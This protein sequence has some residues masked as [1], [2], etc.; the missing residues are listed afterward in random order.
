M[1]SKQARWERNQRAKALEAALSEF[2]SNSDNI[3]SIQLRPSTLA[4]Y[5]LYFESEIVYVGRTTC[6]MTRL[7]AHIS[8]GI[9]FDGVKYLEVKDSKYLG[10][11]ECVYI[12]LLKPKIN[13]AGMTDEYKDRY[14]GRYKSI[15]EKYG[16]ELLMKL[17]V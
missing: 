9:V 4:V 6:L 2:I 5:F 16:A 3:R 13:M 7:G 8:R 10:A 17:T 11:L 15:V 12:C 1:V 14:L